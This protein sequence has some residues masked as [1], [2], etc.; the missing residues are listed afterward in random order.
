MWETL[1]AAYTGKAAPNARSCHAHSYDVCRA[2]KPFRNLLNPAVTWRNC[3]RGAGF[4]LWALRAFGGHATCLPATAQQRS[5]PLGL[6]SDD[7]WYTP[8][9][10][11]LPGSASPASRDGRTRRTAAPCARSGSRPSHG[12]ACPR[13]VSCLHT[14]RHWKLQ[15]DRFEYSQSQLSTTGSM[16]LMLC[17]HR[18]ASPSRRR[19]VVLG[20]LLQ[21]AV[22]IVQQGLGR[23]QVSLYP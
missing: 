19:G 10:A 6:L 2:C 3:F 13:W 15:A 1:T 8:A 20:M 9:L 17:C 22:R 12:G 23:R 11:R 7:S 5:A 21:F 14:S 18:H 16:Q 4:A